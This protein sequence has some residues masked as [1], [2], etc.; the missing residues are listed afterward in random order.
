MVKDVY[1][2]NTSTVAFWSVATSPG[3]VGIQRGNLMWHKIQPGPIWFSTWAEPINSA[4]LYFFL[5]QFLVDFMG[6]A[7]RCS[8]FYCW[9][10]AF[11]YLLLF[12]FQPLYIQAGPT[13]QMGPTC[14]DHLSNWSHMSEMYKFDR[15]F[16]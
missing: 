2:Q 1:D 7:Q 4:F 10:M 12:Y 11:Y 3:H 9:P 15:L 16:S 5:C 14:H 6:L 8:R 13:S